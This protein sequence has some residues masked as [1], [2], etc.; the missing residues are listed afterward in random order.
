LVGAGAYDLA[1]TRRDEGSVIPGGVR[2]IR[3][4]AQSFEPD[5]N[6]VRLNNGD[7][8]TYAR[9]RYFAE[10]AQ[11]RFWHKADMTAAARNVRF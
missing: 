8:V 11:V 1:R 9:R 5:K 3:A 6:T 4:A 2:W 10:I 7:T